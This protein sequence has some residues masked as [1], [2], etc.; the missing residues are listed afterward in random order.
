MHSL[1]LLQAGK[2]WVPQAKGDASGALLSMV[3]AELL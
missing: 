3:K 1:L 2:R